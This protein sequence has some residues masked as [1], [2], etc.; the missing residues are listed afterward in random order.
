MGVKS[1]VFP[2]Q[3]RP[4]MLSVFTLLGCQLCSFA[5]YIS[6]FRFYGGLCFDCSLGRAR[7]THLSNNYAITVN[8]RK[9]TVLMFIAF[10]KSLILKVKIQ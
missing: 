8:R 9:D 5:E 2:F 3:G 6:M 10:P 1:P 7:D 4:L